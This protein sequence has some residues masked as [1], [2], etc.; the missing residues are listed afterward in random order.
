MD[1]AR[2]EAWR[3][4]SDQQKQVLAHFQD[5]GP[6]SDEE[7]VDTYAGPRQAPSG[8]RTRRSELVDRGFIVAVGE[9]LSRFDCP[10]TVWQAI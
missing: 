9:K 7:L 10:M 5:Y 4:L 8:L 1:I 3:R 6:Q 2:F